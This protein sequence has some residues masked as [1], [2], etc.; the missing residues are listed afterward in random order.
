MLRS[1]RV[2]PSRSFLPT[3][4]G[5]A[6]LETLQLL[7]AGAAPIMSSGALPSGPSFPSSYPG[8]GST[9]DNSTLTAAIA[10]IDD[11][12]LKLKL[13]MIDYK[14]D[15]NRWQGDV[16][17]WRLDRNFFSSNLR[18]LTVDLRAFQD[19]YKPVKISLKTTNETNPVT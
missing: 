10:A 7:D 4:L 12:L 6:R 16:N 8:T 9:A 17:G 1:S 14:L 18:D 3:S 2:R 15:Y 19:E 5:L 13:D 11:D